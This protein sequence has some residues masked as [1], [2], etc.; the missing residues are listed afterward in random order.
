[1]IKQI[2]SIIKSVL[3]SVIF[4][5]HKRALEFWSQFESVVSHG[6]LA[7]TTNNISGTFRISAK[8]HVLQRIIETGAYEPEVTIAI[9]NHLDKNGGDCINIG[10]NIGLITIFTAQHIKCA[11]VIAIEP[12]RDAYDHLKKNITANNCSHKVTTFQ[13]CLGSHK[14]TVTLASIPGK[15]EY[16]SIGSIH[17]MFSSGQQT[18][19]YEVECRTL[20]DIVE[21]NST[22]PSLLIIDTEG[23]EHLVFSGATKTLLTYKPAIIFELSNKLL[24]KF[25]S[26]VEDILSVLHGFGYDIFNLR[27][28]EKLKDRVFEGEAIAIHTTAKPKCQ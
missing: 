11:R 19:R 10:A 14:G 28:M 23:A 5:K 27:N 13:C 12:N 15:S 21:D 8:S 20:D 24:S 6:E 16:S 25:G 7:V 26:S 1:M 18:A 9:T 4:R 3:R 17:P 22:R 2:T